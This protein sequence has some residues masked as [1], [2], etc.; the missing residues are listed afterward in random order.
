MLHADLIEKAREISSQTGFRVE[1]LQ[2]G[3]LVMILAKLMEKKIVRLRSNNEKT[4][5]VKAVEEKIGK[6]IE[7]LLAERKGKSLAEIA[8][9]FDI[10]KSTAHSWRK[11]VGM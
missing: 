9:E 2:S 5:S 4:A 1:A 10:V 6:P 8:S 7:T 3:F 11:K